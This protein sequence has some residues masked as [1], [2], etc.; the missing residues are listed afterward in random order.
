MTSPNRPG[1]RHHTRDLPSDPGSAI[2]PG[3]R[4]RVHMTGPLGI[5]G[6]VLVP[7]AMQWRDRELIMRRH[8][9]VMFVTDCM[10]IPCNDTGQSHM[11][12]FSGAVSVYLTASSTDLAY[13]WP[14]HSC[15]PDLNQECF[16]SYR[17]S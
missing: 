1:I 9:S 16:C 5:M 2:R 15:C 14:G 11:A 7:G 13:D 12:Q 4:R 17:W 8:Y 6:S 10:K 3:I